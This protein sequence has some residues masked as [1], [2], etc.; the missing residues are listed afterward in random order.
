MQILKP[1]A[2]NYSQNPRP[3]PSLAPVTTAQDLAPY[4]SLKFLLGMIA[5]IKVHNIFEIQMIKTS[6]P[7]HAR[8]YMK[9]S[10]DCSIG[11]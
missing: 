2:A 1:N 9:L 4:L 3:I 6:P 5:L 8:K 7:M 11:D 10:V